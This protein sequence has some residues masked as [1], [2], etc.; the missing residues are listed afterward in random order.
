MH[1]GRYMHLYVTFASNE[2]PR[3]ASMHL[4][5]ISNIITKLAASTEGRNKFKKNYTHCV[6]DVKEKYQSGKCML[7]TYPTS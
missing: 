1:S 7:K 3:F 2:D 4:F 5:A 6:A